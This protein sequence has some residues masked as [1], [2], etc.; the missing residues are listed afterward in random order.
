MKKSEN[1]VVG[2]QANFFR[3]R[4]WWIS[5]VAF[6]DIVKTWRVL[7]AACQLRSPLSWKPDS[8]RVRSIKAKKGRERREVHCTAQRRGLT[9]TPTTTSHNVAYLCVTLQSYRIDVTTQM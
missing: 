9:P 7:A 5:R 2:Q 6:T 8:V 3:I 4:N 1:Q